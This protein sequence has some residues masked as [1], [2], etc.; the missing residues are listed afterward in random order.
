LLEIR[1]NSSG[2]NGREGYIYAEMFAE[3]GNAIGFVLATTV[4]EENI[5][6][7]PLMKKFQRPCTR[8]NGALAK[9]ENTVNVKGKGIIEGV[10]IAFAEAVHRAQGA[11]ESQ[12]PVTNKEYLRAD[13]CDAALG[14][15]LDHTPK[16]LSINTKVATNLPGDGSARLPN[17]VIN[18]QIG[19]IT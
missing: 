6:N 4:R 19:M 11:P 3:F 9:H 12:L 7:L 5:R 15:D 10:R 14:R 1:Q 13:A 17:T 2:R 16:A 18:A 8:R